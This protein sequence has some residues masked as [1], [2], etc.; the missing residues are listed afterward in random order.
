MDKTANQ[1]VENQITIPLELTRKQ[2]KMLIK[3]IALK[4]KPKTQELLRT[5]EPHTEDK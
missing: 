2:D 4:I 5:Q 1:E 3:V